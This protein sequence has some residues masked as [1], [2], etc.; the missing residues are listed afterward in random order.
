VGRGNRNASALT[1]DSSGP[2]YPALL[3]SLE[4]A[5]H[6]ARTSATTAREQRPKNSLGPQDF[7][8]K[9]SVQSGFAD[10]WQVVDFKELFKIR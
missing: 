6:P 3:F 5:T 8:Y 7:W 1:L 9:G 10:V 2:V 4:G